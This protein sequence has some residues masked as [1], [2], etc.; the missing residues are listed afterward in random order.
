MNMQM[1]EKL[2]N[3]TTAAKNSEQIPEPPK[4]FGM[5]IFYLSAAIGVLAIFVFAI[6]LFIYGHP[7]GAFITIA[8]AL[9]V[10]YM[11]YKIQSADE[12]PLD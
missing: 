1:R 8:I 2:R 5:F 4:K 9:S 7:I 11:L 3:L 6:A 12:L 10:T